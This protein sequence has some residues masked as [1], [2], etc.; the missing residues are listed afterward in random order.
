MTRILLILAAT[1]ANCGP[2]RAEDAEVETWAKEKCIRYERAW[3]RAKDFIGL[4]GVSAEFIKGN[5]K[6]IAEGC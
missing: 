2:I 6:F 4:E 3:N 5:E 1:L